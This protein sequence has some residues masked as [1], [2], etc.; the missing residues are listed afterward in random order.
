MLCMYIAFF[1]CHNSVCLTIV[2]FAI[3]MRVKEN[4]SIFLVCILLNYEA[5]YISNV[6]HKGL[7]HTQK[8][9]NSKFLC[10]LT[11][12]PIFRH[13]L[14]RIKKYSVVHQKTQQFDKHYTRSATSINYVLH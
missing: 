8:K 12:T 7:Q 6:P 10:E 11:V 9:L 3:F 5:T 2:V 14:L 4:R 13:G 1:E